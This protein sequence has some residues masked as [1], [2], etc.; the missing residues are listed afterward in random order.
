M[1]LV[2]AI[3]CPDEALPVLAARIAELTAGG[4]R[5]IVAAKPTPGA[6][7]ATREG[8]VPA[9]IF[10]IEKDTGELAFVGGPGPEL[11]RAIVLPTLADLH[12]HIW[13]LGFSFVTAEAVALGP[14]PALVIVQE[15]LSDP[16]AVDADVE[17]LRA[18][19]PGAVVVAASR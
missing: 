17:S 4:A 8:D 9:Q 15:R 10:R 6:A 14:A 2:D 18:R 3:D 13:L 11:P 7:L 16:A 12:E 5:G 1:F 19:W